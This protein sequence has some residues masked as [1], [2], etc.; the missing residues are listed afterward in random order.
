M[1]L[2]LL[3]PQAFEK[4]QQL[5]WSVFLEKVKSY[6]YFR[7]NWEYFDSPQLYFDANKL[8]SHFELIENMTSY[9]L[10]TR[11]DIFRSPSLSELSSELIG[12]LEKNGGLNLQEINIISLLIE[13]FESLINSGLVDKIFHKGFQAP[14]KFK[15]LTKL[16][17]YIRRYV[18]TKAQIVTDH[19][20]E[21]K[22]LTERIYELEHKVRSELQKILSHPD[23]DERL[24]NKGIDFI[25]DHYVITVKSDNYQSELGD[26]ISHSQSGAS[27][28][29]EP[30]IIRDIS[31]K[32]LHAKRD[33]NKAIQK[34]TFDISRKLFG[35]YDEIVNIRDICLKIDQLQAQSRLNLHFGLKKPNI[36][37]AQNR[38]VEYINLFHPMIENPVRNHI[39]LSE[40]SN[41]AL[42][43]GPNTGG[44]TVTLKSIALTQLL[45]Q[46]GFFAPNDSCQIPLYKALYFLGNDDQTVQEGLSSFSSEVKNYIQVLEDANSPSLIIIDEIFNST[47]SEEASA[48]AYGFIKEF[49]S[50]ENKVFISSHHSD[51]KNNIFENKDLESFHMGFKK[52]DNIP[53]YKLIQGS[54]G[55]SMALEVFENIAKDSPFE[56]KIKTTAYNQLENLHTQY[57]KLI[58]ELSQQKSKVEALETKLQ[59]SKDE[60][61][62]QKDSYRHALKME[63]DKLSDELKN[64]VSSI[65]AKFLKL[66][67]QYSF[68]LGQDVNQQ[69]KKVETSLKEDNKNL[70]A[71]GIQLIQPKKPI[72]VG[73]YL[74]SKPLGQT[75]TILKL[76]DKEALASL[77]KIK[78]KVKLTDLYLPPNNNVAQK[79]SK[80]QKVFVNL[81]SHSEFKTDY[82]ARGMRLDEF[83]NLVS[84]ALQGLTLGNL[85]YLRI[86]H[87]H[88]TGVLKKYLRDM[89]K[90]DSD[91]QFEPC[92]DSADGATIIKLS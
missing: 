71:D 30:Q 18:D 25:N 81:D 57:E 49:I 44:K 24:Q 75:I 43:S 84:H 83:E 34:I 13:N 17:K 47:S 79:T 85:P 16:V 77:G 87:G 48:L 56:N 42:I 55:S 11:T 9:L 58:I 86:I 5:D 2:N 63:Y 76:F 51:L 60:F 70:R 6:C 89:L 3:H 66:Q 15:E 61:D 54:P 80:K 62:K 50:E 91:Y 92:K 53:T 33:L 29:V 8:S 69:I 36:I 64:Q 67:K 82:D 59:D 37:T 26:I 52:P 21:L 38:S 65:K 39:L 35:F 27:L 46:S 68:K 78:L 22:R 1:E 12:R 88:G 14:D 45:V 20:P 41:G 40:S 90:N 72:K 74:F 28:Y 10:E 32:I 23:W 7:Q 19:D 73:D 31:T 4:R